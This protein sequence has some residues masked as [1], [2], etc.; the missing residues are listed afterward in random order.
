MGSL[1]DEVRYVGEVDLHINLAISPDNNL[2]PT[3]PR[4]RVLQSMIAKKFMV[5]TSRK[6]KDVI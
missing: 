2:T 4:T 6:I 1:W 5:M 3:D